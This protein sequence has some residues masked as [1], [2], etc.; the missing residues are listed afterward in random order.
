[1]RRTNTWAISIPQAPAPAG[2]TLYGEDRLIERDT[3][4][5]D[6]FCAICAASWPGE[7]PNPAP[8]RSR[9]R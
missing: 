4:R 2:Y 6:W 7:G 8:A 1:M 3:G 5:Q 9:P